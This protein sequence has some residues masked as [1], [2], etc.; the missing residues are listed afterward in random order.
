M[1]WCLTFPRWQR[2]GSGCHCHSAAVGRG[3]GIRT[4]PNGESPRWNMPRPACSWRVIVPVTAVGPRTH[5]RVICPP[6]ARNPF[7]RLARSVTVPSE[8]VTPSVGR[9]YQPGLMRGC[10][11]TRGR[12][13]HNNGL[14]G[15][16]IRRNDYAAI[17]AQATPFGKARIDDFLFPDRFLNPED[18]VSQQPRRGRRAVNSLRCRRQSETSDPA[19]PN[20]PPPDW[21]DGRRG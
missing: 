7:G 15:A 12:R 10:R 13:E 2:R 14:I 8:E 18:K 16:P 20:F 3:W 9:P 17:D 19:G 11:T 4:F 5:I 21:L 6:A 1:S